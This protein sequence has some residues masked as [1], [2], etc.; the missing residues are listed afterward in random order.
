VSA[1]IIRA[2][3]RTA[4]ALVALAALGGCAPPTAIKV[5]DGVSAYLRGEFP[6]AMQRFVETEG[7][8]G[9]LR[10]EGQVRYLVFRGLAAY[11]LGQKAEAKALLAKGKRAYEAGDPRWLPPAA[12]A[13]MNTV[14][15]E[16]GNP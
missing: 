2:G 15:G 1:P 11:H 5:Q 7:D 16:L 4:A 14:L 9:N 6:G 8:Q 12:V 3:G 13:E 10:P